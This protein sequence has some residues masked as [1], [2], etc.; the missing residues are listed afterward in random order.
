[1]DFQSLGIDGA[2]IARSQ[3]HQ[4]DRGG[5]REWFRADELKKETDFDFGVV[6]AN[7]SISRKDTLRGIHYSLAKAGQAKW[8]TCAAGSILDVVVDLRP[9][10]PTFKKSIA[11]ELSAERGEGLVIATGLGHGF[12]ALEDQSV[13]SYLLTSEYS[14]D[15][16]Y[17]INPY[18]VELAI[19]WPNGIHILSQ[20]DK[21][22]PSLSDRTSQGRLPK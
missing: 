21:N 5:F 14:P 1:M 4:D 2:W 9:T 6:Q 20:Q 12:L 22:A 19:G 17:G 18:D 7:L 15:Q 3:F 16:E 10:S 8:V 13:V 11:V